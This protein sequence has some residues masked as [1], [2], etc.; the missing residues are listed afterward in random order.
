MRCHGATDICKPVRNSTTVN[1]IT[2]SV[3]VMSTATVTVD[4]VATA[5]RKNAVISEKKLNTTS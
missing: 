4:A 3:S 2:E 5:S 1:T